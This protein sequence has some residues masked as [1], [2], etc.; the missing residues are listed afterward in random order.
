ML[1]QIWI[2]AED[3]CQITLDAVQILNISEGLLKRKLKKCIQ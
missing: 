2:M 3:G 1:E